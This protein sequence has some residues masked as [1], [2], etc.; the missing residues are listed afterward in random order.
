MSLNS[1]KNILMGYVK[2]S[3][4]GPYCLPLRNQNQLLKLYCEDNNYIYS[5]PQAEPIFSKNYIQL[6]SFLNKINKNVGLVTLS[7]YMM[8]ENKNERTKLLNSLIKKKSE[9]HFVFENI[10]VNS[11]KSLKKLE[12]IVSYQKNTKKT[13]EIY[14]LIKKK[15]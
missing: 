13:Y 7:I 14:N 3:N 2:N 9:I 8:P 10:I 6:F 4:F 11:F 5:L 1:K 12:Q 15:I